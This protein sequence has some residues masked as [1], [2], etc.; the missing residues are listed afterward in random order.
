MKKIRNK[1]CVT[2]L[3]GCLK[4]KKKNQET[5]YFKNQISPRINQNLKLYNYDNVYGNITNTFEY[6]NIYAS[7]LQIKLFVF[8]FLFFF[9]KCEEIF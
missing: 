8:F 9:D 6:K 2:V 1:T 3:K 4:T 5:H 7:S